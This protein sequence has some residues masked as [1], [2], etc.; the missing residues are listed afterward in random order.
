VIA[1]QKQLKTCSIAPF[2]VYYVLKVGQKPVLFFLLESYSVLVM[3]W[4]DIYMSIGHASYFPNDDC[5]LDD[6]IDHN[7]NELV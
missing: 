4:S 3:L 5:P 1:P 2:F 7:L 6:E